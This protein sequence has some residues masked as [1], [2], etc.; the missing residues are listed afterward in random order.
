MTISR[1]HIAPGAPKCSVLCICRRFRWGGSASQI[2][3]DL[4]QV[5]AR[6]MIHVFFRLSSYA[7]FHVSIIHQRFGAGEP[8]LADFKAGI[9]R[10]LLRSEVRLA[11]MSLLPA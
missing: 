2:R 1:V 6:G 10:L 8:V 3:L 7:R 9:G 5:G 4:I 11:S